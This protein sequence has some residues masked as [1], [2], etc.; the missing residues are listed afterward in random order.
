MI[1][2]MMQSDY[3]PKGWRKS[4]YRALCLSCRRDAVDVRD[5]DD[6]SGSDV[7][8][9]VVVCNVGCGERR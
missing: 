9:A 3:Q 2:L 8:H 4:R 6:C 1:P 7:G 5:N